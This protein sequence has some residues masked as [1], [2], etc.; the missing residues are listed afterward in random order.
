M[1]DPFTHFRTPH[2]HFAGILA[3]WAG[4]V[5]GRLGTEN[6]IQL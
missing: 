6:V 4:L 3:D 2:A 5:T 1:R